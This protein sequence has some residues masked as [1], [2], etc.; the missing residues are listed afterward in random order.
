MGL[1]LGSEGL[2]KV[3]PHHVV[4]LGSPKIDPFI[5]IKLYLGSPLRRTSRCGTCLEFPSAHR[6]V[7]HLNLVEQ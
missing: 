4:A 3:Y 5:R 1:N 2:A 7:D 6:Y